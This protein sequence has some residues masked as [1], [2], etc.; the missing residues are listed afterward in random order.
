MSLCSGTEKSGLRDCPRSRPDSAV[1]ISRGDASVGSPQ[2]SICAELRAQRVSPV[3]AWAM[4]G[5][6]ARSS[7]WGQFEAESLPGCMAGFKA[8]AVQHHE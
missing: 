7:V 6:L 2:G 1:E 8:Q 5:V 4:T 3:G